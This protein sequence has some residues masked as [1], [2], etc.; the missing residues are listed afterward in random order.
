MHK[1]TEKDPAA[2]T[3]VCSVCGPVSLARKGKSWRCA[4]RRRELH[5]AW[6]E[7]NPT[8]AAASRAHVSP[9]K[10]TN[11]V[12]P[13]CGPVEAVPYGRGWACPNTPGAK[14]RL[15]QQ[16]APQSRC[17]DCGSFFSVSEGICLSCSIT[18]TPGNSWKKI[19]AAYRGAG[20]SDFIYELT[21]QSPIKHKADH[22]V[23]DRRDRTNPSMKT[24]G[25]KDVPAEWAWAVAP[26]A[27]WSAFDA[28]ANA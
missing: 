18:N 12:C 9:H 6:V 2:R 24:L 21:E 26:G 13:L 28:E 25:S 11:G 20:V 15:V 4:N 3:G 27:D 10:V 23:D 14:R 19:D 17:R 5:Q 22:F 8:K 7:E 1:L 16:S